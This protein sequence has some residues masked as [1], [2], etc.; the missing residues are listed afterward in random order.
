MVS[1]V[2]EVNTLYRFSISIISDCNTH[3]NLMHILLAS[4]AVYLTHNNPKSLHS[5]IIFIYLVRIPRTSQRQ[6]QNPT[7]TAQIRATLITMSVAVNLI[8]EA[9]M[10][11][12]GSYAY[13][14]CFYML[15][16]EPH[17]LMSYVLPCHAKKKKKR[18]FFRSLGNRDIQYL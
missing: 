12:S 8:A 11:Q 18:H 6:Q 7:T 16:H 17:T 4:S 1:S 9:V 2:E 3:Q 13:F 10:R 14:L 15:Q 5:Q